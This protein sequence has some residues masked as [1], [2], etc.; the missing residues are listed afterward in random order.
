MCSQSACAQRHAA[1]GGEIGLNRIGTLFNLLMA[2]AVF[3]SSLALVYVK[4]KN[5]EQWSELQQLQEAR[6]ELE[7]EWSRL[8]LE[9]GAWATAPRIERL[10]RDR[11]GMSTPVAKDIRLVPHE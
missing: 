6:D 11:L 5:R 7:G 4:F 10:A 8:Q 9:L 1:G 2:L 3:V